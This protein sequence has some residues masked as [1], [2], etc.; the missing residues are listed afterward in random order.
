MYD[1]LDP[2]AVNRLKEFLDK[3]TDI[4]IV[5]SSS[6]RWGD[7]GKT[8]EFLKDTGLKCLIPYYV[9]DT[10]RSYNGHRGTE[11]K[12]FIETM[13]KDESKKLWKDETPFTIEK[14]AIVDDDS[15]MLDEQLPFFVHTDNYYGIIEDDYKKIEKI[16]YGS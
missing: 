7:Y 3:H 10:V 6:W 2:D 5:L 4:R 12:H 16:L 15:D 14:Y 11:V 1:F 8:V 9:G 13:G